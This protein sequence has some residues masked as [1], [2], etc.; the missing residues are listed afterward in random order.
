MSLFNRL[1]E[2]DESEVLPGNLDNNENDKPADFFFC[3]N[4]RYQHVLVRKYF[5]IEEEQI[6]ER[7]VSAITL[8]PP[9]RQV[10]KD[11]PDLYGPFWIATTLIVIII[12]SASLITFFASTDDKKVTYE[13][14]QIPVATSLVFLLS[15]RSMAFASGLP[16]S[17]PSW[18]GSSEALSPWSKSSVSTATA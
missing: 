14:T 18:S 11:K 13:F 16:I 9:F 4:I 7:M 3:L 8:R 6:K 12:A 2:K 5:E 17:S 10:I 1:L 15:C